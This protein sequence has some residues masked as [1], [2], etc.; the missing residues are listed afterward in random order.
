MNGDHQRVATAPLDLRTTNREQGTPDCN[1]RVRDARVTGGLP[2]PPACTGTDSSERHCT[3]VRGAL[4]GS[5]SV[6]SRKR[7][8]DKSSL[9][10]PLRKR[11][12]PVEPETERQSLEPEIERAP[13][14]P[15][16]RDRFSPAD[17]RERFAGHAADESR[18][19]PA[20][21]TPRRNEVAGQSPGGYPI[22]FLYPLD[23]GKCS[24]V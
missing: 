1:G 16:S 5:E 23:Y 2:A 14:R 13:I 22:P 17:F 15:P 3:A 9:R 4:P 7:S 21:A 19:G 24:C 18:V 11:P 10:L 20:S 8:A 6:A 12:I